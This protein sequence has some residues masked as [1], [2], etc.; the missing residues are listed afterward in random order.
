MVTALSALIAALAVF[1][2]L[3]STTTT[4]QPIDSLLNVLGSWVNGRT[5]RVL[6]ADEAASGLFYAV[7]VYLLVFSVTFFVLR[8]LAIFTAAL[9]IPDEERLRTNRDLRRNRG[10]TVAAMRRQARFQAVYN[11]RA[12]QAYALAQRR[13]QAR[14]AARAAAP[15]PTLDDFNL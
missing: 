13:R 7:I 10:T 4:T 12:Q 3:G 1:F 15:E 9:G 5:L 11:V 6:T 14:A 2:A 8:V